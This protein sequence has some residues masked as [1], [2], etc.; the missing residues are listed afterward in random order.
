M[1]RL[2]RKPIPIPAG[3][4]V[5]LDH[6][7]INVVGKLGKLEVKVLP[8]IECEITPEGVRIWTDKNIFK[9]ALMLART[10]LF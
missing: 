4:E 6:K 3:V 2:V 5:K 10:P 7:V 8:L 1:S 9:L